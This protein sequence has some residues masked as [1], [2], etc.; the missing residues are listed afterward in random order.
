MVGRLGRSEALY[1]M[2]RIAKVQIYME[3]DNMKIS[4]NI[5]RGKVP[6]SIF[7]FCTSVKRNLYDIRLRK[8]D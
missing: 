2:A 7:P 4:K 1:T 3:S 8:S 6:L 5:P